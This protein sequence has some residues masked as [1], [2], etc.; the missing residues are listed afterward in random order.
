MIFGRRGEPAERTTMTNTPTE[1]QPDTE[2]SA[3]VAPAVTLGMAGVVT[4]VL[5]LFVRWRIETF[6]SSQ[7]KAP[8][9]L[10]ILHSFSRMNR[11][12]LLTAA[13]IVASI[14]VA[15]GYFRTPEGRAKRDQIL[16]RRPVAGDLLEHD[17]VE[18]FRRYFG[19]AVIVFVV[20]ILAVVAIVFVSAMNGLYHQVNLTR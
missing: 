2:R 13:I 8:L 14:V 17:S 7:T 4:F 5:T 10:R 6:F 12:G 15:A 19:P 9:P 11:L 1:P 3:L 20:I 18:R 16:V